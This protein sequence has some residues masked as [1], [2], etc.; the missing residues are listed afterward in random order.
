MYFIIDRDNLMSALSIV[1]RVVPS[2]NPLPITAG[3]LIRTA[4]NNTVE[5]TGTDLDV[6]IR[7]RVPVIEVLREGEAVVPAR[8]VSEIIRRLGEGK[9]EIQG[10]GHSVIMT[11]PGGEVQ[12]SGY[13]SEEFPLLAQEDDEELLIKPGTGFRDALRHV[14]YAA[15]KDELRPV[16]TGVQFELRDDT[17]TLAA[18]NG[19]RLAV[20]QTT[21]D[22]KTPV[23]AVIPAKALREAER[24]MGQSS[25][26]VTISL[27]HKVA[28]FFLDE[29]EMYTRLIEGRF[30][31]WRAAVPQNQANT[32]VRGGRL[33]LINTLE[34]A[35]VMA[36]T[37][38]PS[39]IIKA[40][41]GILSVHSQSDMGGLRETLSMET[42][43]EDVEIAFNS[44]YLLEALRATDS[45]LIEISFY[46]SI[47]P[48]V[49]R[50]LD[51]PRYL[52]LVLP[53]RLV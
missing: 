44:T 8:P 10:S 35:Q 28:A 50:S 52:A 27:G 34:R 16:F 43:G 25:D 1:L 19:H 13:L 48:A 26:E 31:E 21:V 51:D 45:E 7:C 46:G 4:E 5:L 22:V 53:L 23:S 3:V 47:G 15:G 36:G 11:Y 33:T 40:A 6:M 29:I 24:V 9:V 30:P 32:I 2:R 14:L 41:A 38:I 17:L 37:D 12:L 49:I 39:V 20:H 18:T 42:Q